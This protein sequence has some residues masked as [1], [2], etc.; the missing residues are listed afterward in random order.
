VTIRSRS[1]AIAGTAL[2]GAVAIMSLM[3]LAT[4]TK[5]EPIATIGK[6]YSYLKTRGTYLSTTTYDHRT[7]SVYQPQAVE[8]WI[9]ED[10]SGRQRTV[11]GVPRFVGPRNRQAWEDA[12]RPRFLAHGFRAHTGD[13]FLPAGSF[14]DRLYSPAAIA[15]MPSD[16]DKLSRWLRAQANDPLNGGGPGNGF[17]D[18][19]RTLEL[20]A[21]LLQNPL[22]T[23]SQRAALYAAESMVPGIED[24]GQTHDEIGRWGVAI[25]ARSAN[26]GAPTLY[27][28]IFDPRTSRVLASET[29]MLAAA[30]ALI[31]EGMPVVSSTVYLTEGRTASRRARPKARRSQR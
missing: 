24:L 15:G 9:G 28:L 10:G 22:V 18:S 3:A 4:P 31:D 17:P 30:P 14:T 7:W 11:S 5:G 23:S 1:T 27:S 6:P 26:S 8:Q 25:G 29:A 2:A 16:P 19:A 12:G 20:V 13:E 21:E